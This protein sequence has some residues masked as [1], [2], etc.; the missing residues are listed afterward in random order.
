MATLKSKLSHYLEA[1][2]KGEEIVITSHRHPVAR[3]LPLAK[4]PSD[5]EIAAPP[6]RPISSLR[7]IEGTRLK[8]DPV[9]YLLDDRRLR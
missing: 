3:L 5:L 7:K 8:F 6:I 4:S 9:D 1:V 2:K